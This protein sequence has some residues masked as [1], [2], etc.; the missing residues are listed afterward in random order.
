MTTHEQALRIAVD[1]IGKSIEWMEKV[2][3]YTPTTFDDEGIDTAMQSYKAIAACRKALAAPQEEPVAWMN[4]AGTQCVMMNEDIAI[5]N[6]SDY[7]TIPLYKHP[8]PSPLS[9]ESAERIRDLEKMVAALQLF[10]KETSKFSATPA[11]L[12]DEQIIEIARGWFEITLLNPL[13][14]D[15]IGFSRA[16]E[17]HVRGEK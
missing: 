16:I 9:D 3:E 1:A 13:H 8:A 6:W 7:F 12:T 4:P 15:L 14:H 5:P 2:S 17:R 11:P 10:I